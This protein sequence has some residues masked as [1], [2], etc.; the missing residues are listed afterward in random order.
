MRVFLNLNYLLIHNYIFIM[1]ALYASGCSPWNSLWM[2]PPPPPLSTLLLISFSTPPVKA[3]ESPLE[4][5]S[6]RGFSLQGFFS[7]A[8][9]H[10]A[11]VDGSVFLWLCEALWEAFGYDLVHWLIDCCETVQHSCAGRPVTDPGWSGELLLHSSLGQ[12]FCLCLVACNW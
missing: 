12:E 6:A 2:P 7:R 10:P 8:M 3:D 4:S 1:R 11:A 9:L 5:G